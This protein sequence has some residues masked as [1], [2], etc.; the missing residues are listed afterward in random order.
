MRPYRG[1]RS[2][3]HAAWRLAA[4][5][6]L[7]VFA[8]LA[9]RPPA[10]GTQGDE[11]P[12]DSL[13]RQAESLADADSAAFLYELYA[14]RH[15]RTP[16]ARQAHLRLGQ[17]FYARAEYRDAHR[18]FASVTGKGTLGEEA[19]LGMA[20]CR[21]ALGQFTEARVDA[22]ELLRSSSARLAWEG[23]YVV[24]LSLQ[25]EG[26]TREALSEYLRL[27]DRPAG[28]AQPAALL[29][30]ARAARSEGQSRQ[31]GAGLTRLKREYPDA[32]EAMEADTV[33]TEPGAPPA[34][35][36]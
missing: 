15:G 16:R 12:A 3:A 17:Y 23:G 20:R 4:L 33:Q 1:R 9:W 28:P 34:E 31:A 21:L 30:A 8:G 24:A 13:W 22:S 27:L 29:L 19:R 5:G 2:P 11:S 25:G 26:R 35:T 18:Q 14:A 10:A 32:F 6:A 7:G 36:P